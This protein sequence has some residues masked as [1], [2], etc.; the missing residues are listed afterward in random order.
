MYGRKIYLI[1]DDMLNV[2]GVTTLERMAARMILDSRKTDNI[3]EC[4]IYKWTGTTLSLIQRIAYPVVTK[5]LQ[6]RPFIAKTKE[7][8]K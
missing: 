5:D 3:C 6:V 2:V 4:L 7:A 1:V 8:K